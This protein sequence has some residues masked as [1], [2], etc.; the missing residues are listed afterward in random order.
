M[1]AI[2]DNTVLSNLAIVRRPELLQQLFGGE[3]AVPT[4]VRREL[5]AGERLRRIPTCNW[6]WL[7]EIKLT[8]AER[9]LAE[10]LGKTLDTGEATCLALAFTRRLILLTDDRDAR[11]LAQLMKVPLSG[12][13]GLLQLGVDEGFLDLPTANSLLAE[14]ISRGYRAPIRTLQELE[15]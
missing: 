6:S 7:K 13:L 4:E 3:V 14:M 9:T 10:R 1:R 15:K 8:R 12:T 2:V 11:R 5:A